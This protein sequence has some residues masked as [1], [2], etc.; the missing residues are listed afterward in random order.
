MVRTAGESLTVGAGTVLTK[1]DLHKALDAGASFIVS[2]TV[3]EEVLTHCLK[4]SIAVFPGAFTPQ[5]I[6]NA[7]CLGATMVKVF[8]AKFFGPAYFKEIKGPFSDIEL[9]ACGGVSPDNIAS[10]FE[11]GASAVAFGASIFKGEWLEAG[12]FKKIGKQLATLITA[13]KA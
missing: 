11:N 4:H 9:L 1:D 7:W 10:F 6:H 12:E 2:P 3:I 8:P 13:Y 5:E